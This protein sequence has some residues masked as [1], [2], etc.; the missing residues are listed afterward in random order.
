MTHRLKVLL[1]VLTLLATPQLLS[2]SLL[3][4]EGM[5]SSAYG[6]K[7]AFSLSEISIGSGY[8]SGSLKGLAGNYQ[9]YPVFVRFGFIVSSLFGMEGRRSSLQLALEPFVNAIDLPEKGVESGC[10]VGLRYF[11]RLRGALDLF[12]EAGGAPMFLSIATGEQGSAGFNFLLQGGSGLQYR[13]TERTALFAGYR[14]RHIS[15]AGL[16]DRSNEG[17]NSE[18]IVAGFS[19][20]Y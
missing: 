9:L 6:K 7:G 12:V 13:L 5:D 16:A 4:D 11:H 18:A 17:I 1:F 20:L 19:W 3:A 2:P 15:H 10:S 8:A 14:F